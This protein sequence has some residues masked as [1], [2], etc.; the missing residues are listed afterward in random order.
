MNAARDG[1]L[2]SFPFTSSDMALAIGLAQCA[3][4]KVFVSWN[5]SLQAI[6]L[7]VCCCRPLNHWPLC[8]WPAKPHNHIGFQSGGISCGW[9]RVFKALTFLCACGEP[10]LVSGRCM[11]WNFGM[12]DDLGFQC[13]LLSGLS[14]F[15]LGLPLCGEEGKKVKLWECSGRPPGRRF[16]SFGPHFQRAL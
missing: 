2:V 13:P 6:S 3:T 15:G 7:M 1:H 10:A 5:A 12:L 4:L 9:E 11:E 8:F 14:P 16:D